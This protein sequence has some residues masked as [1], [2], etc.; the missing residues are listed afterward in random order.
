MQTYPN[1]TVR[2][3]TLGPNAIRKAAQIPPWFPK[4]FGSLSSDLES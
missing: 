2:A 3:V 1:I 4:T